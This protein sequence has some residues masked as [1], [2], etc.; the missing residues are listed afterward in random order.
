MTDIIDKIEYL[1]EFMLPERVRRIEEVLAQ[2]TRYITICAENTFHPEPRLLRAKRVEKGRRNAPIEHDR[3][4]CPVFR[5]LPRFNLRL[6][7]IE[8]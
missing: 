2:R 6:G 8:F 1:K 3:R 7:S 5:R 4:I